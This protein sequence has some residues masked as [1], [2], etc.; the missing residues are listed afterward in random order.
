MAK[1]YEKYVEAF[2]TMRNVVLNQNEIKLEDGS[3]NKFVKDAWF[4]ALSHERFSLD[5]ISKQMSNSTDDTSSDLINLMDTIT[6]IKI[7]Q[8]PKL[9]LAIDEVGYQIGAGGAMI[10]K[11][12]LITFDK[13][14]S[15]FNKSDL[16]DFDD[17]DDEFGFAEVLFLKNPAYK[18]FLTSCFSK[19]KI[20]SK[21]QVINLNPV[22]LTL[23][24]DEEFAEADVQA[25]WREIFEKI[26]PESLKYI[27]IEDLD[28]DFKT[29]NE[30]FT[31]HYHVENIDLEDDLDDDVDDFDFDF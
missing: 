18:E 30:L 29:F 1:D 7:K 23:D 27:D 8:Y 15:E 17:D 5:P 12:N 16:L 3:L 10:P 25:S 4:I 19:F 20:K 6:K 28:V 24:V 9:K 22:I 14:L 26:L 2:I 13:A 21:G 31:I 11:L